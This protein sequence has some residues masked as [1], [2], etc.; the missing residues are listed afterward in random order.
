MKRRVNV[1]NY[2]NVVRRI[3]NIVLDIFYYTCIAVFVFISLR[4]FAFGSYRIPTD[5]METS[6]IPGDY[7]LVNK[8]AYGARLFDLFSAVEGEKVKIKRIPGFTRIKNNDVV[9]FHIPHPTSWGKIEMNMTKYFIKRCIGI[10]GD[11]L[12]IINGI[13]TVNSNTTKWLGN[14]EAQKTMGNKRKEMFAEGVYRTFPWDST[15]NWNIQDFGP[16]YIPRKG[17]Q[18]KLDGKN[19]LLYKKIIEWER[20]HFL[21]LENDTLRD[22]GTIMMDY[23]FTH[24]YYFMGG[25]KVENSQDSRYWGLLPDDLIVGKASFVW[26]SIDPYTDKL[27]YKRLLKKIE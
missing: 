3:G 9:V 14:H 22:N 18:L 24:D 27:R 12:R 21:S 13:Y 26:K 4:V 7:V 20:G 17:D 2:R 5:S 1:K 15:L 11:T 16:L 19:A 10:P 6:I 25:D 23:V 8:L